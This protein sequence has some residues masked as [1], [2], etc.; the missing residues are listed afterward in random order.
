TIGLGMF[1]ALSG[2]DDCAAPDICVTDGVGHVCRQVCAVDGDCTQPPASAGPTAEPRNVG[3]CLLTLTSSTFLTCT[4][5]CNP[6][7]KAGAS[8]CPTGYACGYFSTSSVP[9]LTDC[10]PTGSLA[11][12][13]DCT[14]AN[15][16]AGLVCV[17]T[18]T[19]NRC[20]QVC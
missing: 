10:E 8:G 3:R 16:G 12:G 2:F 15:C 19:T 13:G 4:I 17:S 14:S 11:E 7:T 9:E 20:R 5:A 1:C 18:A 6:V